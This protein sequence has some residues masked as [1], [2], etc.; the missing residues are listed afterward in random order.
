MHFAWAEPRESCPRGVRQ[1]EKQSIRLL[2]TLET[3]LR[4]NQTV[5]VYPPYKAF[6]APQIYSQQT[7]QNL[8]NFA[9]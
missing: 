4:H 3:G 6:L 5:I 2:A 9:L 7:V 8:D 1:K